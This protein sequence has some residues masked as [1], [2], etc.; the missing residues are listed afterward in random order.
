MLREF[1][2]LGA[3]GPEAPSLDTRLVL[4]AFRRMAADP[5]SWDALVEVLPA[6]LQTDT[7][8]HADLRPSAVEAA[9]RRE[10]RPG[11]GAPAPTD[12]GWVVIGATGK[13]LACNE[14]GA[15][16]LEGLAEI[17]LGAPLL[18]RGEENKLSADEALERARAGDAQIVLRLERPGEAPCFALASP[19]ARL[20]DLTDMNASEHGRGA[21]CLLFPAADPASRLWTAV[22]RSFG[23][24]DAEVRLA[25]KLREGLSLQQAADS[26]GVSVN[27]VRNQLRAIFDK[28]GVQRQSDL[29]R[30]LTELA[31]LNAA[32]GGSPVRSSA[33]EEAPPLGRLVLHD[34]RRLSYRDYG[35]AD[36]TPMLSFHEALGSCLL[37]P[38]TEASCRELGLR[39]VAIDRPGFGQSDPRREVGFAAVAGDMAEACD[40]LGLERPVVA[41]AASGA[42]Y[43]LHTAARLGDRA[44]LAL[45][46]SGRPPRRVPAGRNLFAALRSRWEANPWLA[47]SVFAILRARRSPALTGRLLRRVAAL[48]PGD[49]AYLD[50]NPWIVDYICA[51]AGEALAR[52]ARGPAQD[53]AAFSQGRGQEPPE[54]GCPIV[55]WHGA[56]DALAPAGDLLGYLGPRASEVR[57]IDGVGSFMALKHWDE[58]LRRAAQAS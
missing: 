29:V 51:Y 39:I 37:P 57:L 41:G 24:T 54:I 25:R 42:T 58:I 52:S 3:A 49:T 21:A 15:A 45:L 17:K 18:W 56:E 48:S 33:S 7:L 46:C 27:T 32:L 5:A 35:P 28:M 38:G 47:E 43:A 11:E 19:P 53:L 23:L 6:D 34:G 40:L 4:D 13:V 31:T 55:V 36:G 22:R 8:P 16:A 20:P 12:P 30:A 1:E 14:A 10:R 26:L 50:A 2:R 9:A 44:R